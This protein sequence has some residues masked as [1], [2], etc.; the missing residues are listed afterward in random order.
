MVATSE[1]VP[2][3]QDRCRVLSYYCQ[4]L[5][6]G[7]SFSSGLWSVEC[8]FKQSRTNQY[9]VMYDGGQVFPLNGSST[10][11]REIYSFL[12]IQDKFDH[13]DIRYTED[14][15]IYRMGDA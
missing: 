3:Q 8:F 9:L 13:L 15:A 7:D 1:Q 14:G 2:W 11:W 6:S 5:K 4:N 10:N 12:V